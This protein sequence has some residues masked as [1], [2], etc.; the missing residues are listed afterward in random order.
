MIFNRVK[1]GAA[2]HK[3]A[4]SHLQAMTPQ[5][6]LSLVGY[7]RRMSLIGHLPTHD[8]IRKIA[9]YLRCLRLSPTL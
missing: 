5:E 4:A 6:E 1:T 7:I 3:T 8:E 2:D 9:N